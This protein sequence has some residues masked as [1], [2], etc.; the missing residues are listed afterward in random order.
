MLRKRFLLFI[1]LEGMT[2]GEGLLNHNGENAAGP[3]GIRE[4]GAI[5]PKLDG[6]GGNAGGTSASARNRLSRSLWPPGIPYH[7]PQRELLQ[8]LSNIL[9]PFSN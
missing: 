9:F 4:P 8:F 1:Y 2:E 3:S 5:I 6:E 7:G